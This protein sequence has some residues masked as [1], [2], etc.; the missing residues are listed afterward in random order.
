MINTR[1]AIQDIVKHTAGLGFIQVVKLTG[2]DTE[3]QL[4]AM[5][6]DRSVIVTGALHNQLDD[7]K[8]HEIGLGNMGFLGGVVSLPNYQEDDSTVD[9][10]SREKDGEQVPD[11]LMFK[12]TAGNKD[13]YRF[14]NKD[15][16]D[17]SLQTVKFKGV[18][19]DVTFEPTKQKVSELQQVANIYGGI[20]VGVRT[21]DS[22]IAG[23]GGCPY[24]PGASG[25]V[26]TEDLVYML[27]GLD[28]ASGV[29]LEMLVRVSWYISE[30]L[31]REPISKVAKA[32]GR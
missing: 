31:G 16:I 22:S 14:M 2:T 26:A 9:I 19:W 20:E 11:H 18:E 27:N 30:L 12:D 29:D 4:D 24:A 25:N 15:M 8:N 1:D 21:F 3:T 28:F 32:M 23:L 5:D 17:E 10:I 7:L 6:T 13:Q